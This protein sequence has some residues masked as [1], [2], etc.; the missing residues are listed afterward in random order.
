MH[1]DAER[2][3]AEHNAYGRTHAHARGTSENRHTEGATQCAFFR[4]LECTKAVKAAHIRAFCRLYKNPVSSLA[5]CNFTSNISGHFAKRISGK[6][7]YKHIFITFI[8]FRDMYQNHKSQIKSGVNGQ[9]LKHMFL[10]KTVPKT[11][12]RLAWRHFS[13]L[14]VSWLEGEKGQLSYDPSTC[15]ACT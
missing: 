7:L 1:K 6:Q 4:A 10:L 3:D 2:K 14:C 9:K 5:P 15:A 8:Q 13:P 12:G 11:P